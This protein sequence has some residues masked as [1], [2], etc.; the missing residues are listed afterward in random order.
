MAGIIT[1]DIA[2]QAQEKS[3]K[4]FSR[5]NTHTKMSLGEFYFLLGICGN[6]KNVYRSGKSFF[7]RGL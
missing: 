5:Q 6:G 2:H 7:K 3:I 1:F 4:H